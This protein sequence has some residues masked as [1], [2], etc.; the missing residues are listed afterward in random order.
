M[1]HHIK[2]C[3]QVTSIP[4]PEVIPEVNMHLPGQECHIVFITSNTGAALCRTSCGLVGWQK[5]VTRR[6]SCSPFQAIQWTGI[7]AS[8]GFH[9]QPKKKQKAGADDEVEDAAGREARWERV[10]LA[11][12]KQ[13][14]RCG[15]LET[16][17]ANM[18]G[19][20][21]RASHPGPEQ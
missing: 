16:D 18:S 4:Q 3:G 12:T 14:L 11:A 5:M 7:V 13:S 8:A 21:K 15:R 6:T 2:L 19:S 10:A 1:I 17:L 20:S 9:K